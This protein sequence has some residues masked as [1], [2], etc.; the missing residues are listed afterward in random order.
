[1]F[2]TQIPER[3]P[4]MSTNKNI[5]LHR[6]G[7]GK[8]LLINAI[9]ALAISFFFCPDC[10]T[11]LEGIKN[12]SV[13]FLYSFAM[14]T[15]LS[16]G[17]SWLEEY[18]G[19]RI[20]WLEAPGKRLLLEVFMITVYSSVASFIITFF[21]HWYHGYFT[22]DNIRWEFLILNVIYPVLVA[23]V[24]TAFFMARAF[25]LEWR[26]AAVDAE[27]LRAEQFAGKY[28]MLRDQLNPHFLFNSLN[29]L[30]NIVYEDAD[31]AADF[32]QQL[33]R[34]YRYVLE[35]QKEELVDLEKEI[36]FGG[37][38]LKLQQLRFG[39]NLK[40]DWEKQIPKGAMIPPLSLQ[41]VLENA[42]KHNEISNANPLNIKISV[43]DNFI[44]VE[45][46]IQK[47]VIEDGSSTGVGLENIKERYRLLSD[48]E[49]EI[50]D[51]GKVY[52]VS[53]PLIKIEG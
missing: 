53:L 16:G 35:I 49:V 28:R 31:R 3:K 34:F 30:S 36:D 13:N 11:S 12:A 41:L 2:V 22:L 42:V 15:T 47:K 24:L 52:S 1:M 33:S 6:Q 46:A 40:V 44:T 39:E 29:V 37:R 27:K 51:D 9:I 10:F 26:Q 32:I 18:V 50:L 45:N 20:P 5:A 38:Y 43:N 7:L 25:L 21:F 19:N 8:F 48:R 23:Y 17:I 14:S 4:G